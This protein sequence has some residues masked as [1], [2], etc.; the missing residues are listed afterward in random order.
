MKKHLSPS[1]FIAMTKYCQAERMAIERNE[2]EFVKSDPILIGG[3]IDAHFSGTMDEFRNEN[4]GSFFKK[5]GTMYAKFEKANEIIKVAEA[6]E[7]FMKYMSG[8]HQFKVEGTIAGVPY[9]GYLDAYHAKKAISELKVVKS[10]RDTTWNNETKSRENFIQSN[11]Y[12][13]QLAIYQELVFQMTGDRLPVYLLALSKE[14]AIDKEVIFVTQWALD[15]AMDTIK[16]R[17]KEFLAIRQGKQEPTRCESCAYCRST[18]MI[19]EPMNYEEFFE[20]K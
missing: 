16:D 20:T 6:D 2:V 13:L 4:T 10:I 14:T 3:Y 18:R 7:V 15:F 9:L 8:E 11:G 19:K 1:F 17:S 12:L 5:D